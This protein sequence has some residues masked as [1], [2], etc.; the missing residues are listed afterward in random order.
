MKNNNLILCHRVQKY[1][2]HQ[3]KSLSVFL[4]GVNLTDF[5]IFL[6]MKIVINVKQQ[7]RCARRFLLFKL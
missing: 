1:N 7:L 4:E 2:F 3:H 5:V 6:V